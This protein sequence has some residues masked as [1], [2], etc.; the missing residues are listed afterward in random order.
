LL[1]LHLPIRK[2]VSVLPG[3]LSMYYMEEIINTHTRR[4]VA[5]IAGRLV[6]G[7]K[8]SS[9]YDYG[10]RRHVNMSGNLTGSSISA[11]DY[12][13]RCYIS[14]S[15][16]SLYH[17]GNGAHLTLVLNAA[18]FSGYDYDS[19]KH[20]S[21]NVSGKTVSLYDYQTATHYSYSI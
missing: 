17:Y 10:E 3:S 1:T 8:G 9:I 5:Y 18:A 14:G 11:Y 20:F 7:K 4:A 21:G 13:Q 19:K 16:T 6:S 2:N 12:D 15:R